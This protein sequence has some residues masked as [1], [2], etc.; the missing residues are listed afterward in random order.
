MFIRKIS[1]LYVFNYT[2]LGNKQ[3][4]HQEYCYI[5]IIVL[6]SCIMLFHKLKYQSASDTYGTIY[7]QI[8]H[9]SEFTIYIIFPYHRNCPPFKH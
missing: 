9:I 3:I 1:A 5:Y 6:N 4:A 7:R 8:V 2:K